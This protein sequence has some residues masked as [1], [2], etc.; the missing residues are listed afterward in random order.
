MATF[1]NLQDEALKMLGRPGLAAG[2]DFRSRIKFWLNRAYLAIGQSL[3]LP[4]LH[5]TDTS[6]PSVASQQAYALPADCLFIHSIT[7]DHD[8]VGAKRLERKGIA[9]LD[10]MGS[11]EAASPDYYARFLNQFHLAPIPNAVKNMRVRYY[12][13]PVELSADADVPVMRRE[14][15][16]AILLLGSQYIAIATNR[17]DAAQ[18]FQA[19]FQAYISIMRIT[20][21]SLTLGADEGVEVIGAQPEFINRGAPGTVPALGVSGPTASS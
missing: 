15:D 4:D 5:K 13:Q 12:S 8:T 18:A 3:D 17:L 20:G 10:A 7:F 14:W 2:D 6:V 19:Q 16:L 11:G 21:H 9:P 1:V